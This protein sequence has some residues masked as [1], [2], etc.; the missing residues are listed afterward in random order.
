[1]DQVDLYCSVKGLRIKLI[2]INLTDLLDPTIY[3]PPSHTPITNAKKAPGQFWYLKKMLGAPTIMLG[4]PN[5]T[6]LLNGYHICF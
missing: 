3:G 1:M 2:R 6:P 4:A 5:N